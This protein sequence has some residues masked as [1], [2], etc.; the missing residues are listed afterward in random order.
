[1]G[2]WCCISYIWQVWTEK[3]YNPL[4]H[5][6]L[7]WYK[8]W[9]QA[10]AAHDLSSYLHPAGLLHPLLGTQSRYVMGVK[11]VY[12]PGFT[13]VPIYQ[14]ARKWIWTTWVEC[15]LP[16]LVFVASHAN[17]C[18]IETRAQWIVLLKISL[19]VSIKNL[20][21]VTDSSCEVVRSIYFIFW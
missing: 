5:V 7:L 10:A 19:I 6:F 3:S 2:F 21:W 4:R 16:W 18:T 14:P 12:P 8:F 9:A 20:I 15:A 11:P 1:M 13:L 17:H